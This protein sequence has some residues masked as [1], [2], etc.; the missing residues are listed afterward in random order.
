MADQANTGN[1]ENG[2]YLDIEGYYDKI[3]RTTWARR[4]AGMMAGVT[5]GAA[6]GAIVGAAA[7]FVPYILGITLGAAAGAAVIPISAAVTALP[8]SI[9]LFAG[10]TAMVGMA[11]TTDVVANAASSAVGLEEKERREKIEEILESGTSSPAIRHKEKTE[12]GPP[13]FSWKIAAVTVP[14]FAAFGALIAY[15]PF[16][17]ALMFKE[18][19]MFSGL[20][21]SAAVAASASVFGMF[22]T[23]LGM[24]SSLFSN[25]LTNFYY[26]LVTEELFHKNP[27][28]GTSVQVQAQPQAVMEKS[29]DPAVE[30]TAPSKSFTDKTVRFSFQGLIEKGDKGSPDQNVIL[31]R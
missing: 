22:G 28:K 2:Y 27:Q 23:F 16:T 24:K 18:M 20:T 21:G 4:T 5:L 11:V 7:A 19:P 8:A 26:K 31:T 29:I 12:P 3:H 1:G 6:Y 9:A 30:Q 15:N 10:I 13:L 25:V 14:L 17:A